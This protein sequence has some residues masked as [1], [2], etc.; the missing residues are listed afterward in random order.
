MNGSRDMNICLKFGNIRLM[1]SNGLNLALLS[2]SYARE[3]S[4]VSEIR[5]LSCVFNGRPRG[6]REGLLSD[7]MKV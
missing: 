2:I 1:V 6:E 7:H 5:S 3:R 4:R